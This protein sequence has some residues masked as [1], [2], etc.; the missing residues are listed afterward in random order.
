MIFP[1]TRIS[2]NILALEKIVNDNF[3]GEFSESELNEATVKAY[4]NTLGDKYS[5]YVTNDKTD[6]Y[7]ANYNGD[8][9]GIG[10]NILKTDEG[11]MLIVRVH[12]ASP[13]NKAG[14]KVFDIVTS[15]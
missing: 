6:E 3:D 12:D 8:D 2:D 9:T 15:M 4:I 5:S 11:K 13:A 14:L 10:I 7:K 1:Q